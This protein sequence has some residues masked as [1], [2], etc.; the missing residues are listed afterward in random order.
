MT[1][2]PRPPRFR[3]VAHARWI[4]AL[5]PLIGL[6][7]ASAGTAQSL[8]TASV[9]GVT[10]TT[11]TGT[12]SQATPTTFGNHAATAQYGYLTTDNG[13]AIPVSGSDSGLTAVATFQD[14]LTVTHPTATGGGT[15]RARLRITG[16]PEYTATRTSS[17]VAQGVNAG[18]QVL[19]VQ[20]GGT[21]NF[22]DGAVSYSTGVMPP[23][24]ILGTVPAPGLV[25]VSFPF[26]FGVSTNIGMQLSSN[27]SGNNVFF[28]P[29]DGAITGDSHVVLRWAGIVS[30]QDNVG[31][32]LLST[33]SVAS[34]SGTDWS[35]PLGPPPVPTGPPWTTAILALGLFG[36]ATLALAHRTDS[37]TA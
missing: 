7:T 15:L 32:E 2:C 19:R 13:V 31:N 37:T 14:D 18:Y 17:A 6:V 16:G 34:G 5:V 33:A 22:E 8:L 36:V 27:A 10:D 29:E 12:A 24:T 35:G 28:A 20:N 30:I 1:A 9:G 11:P 21:F 23:E 3:P 25:E 4:A 26:V